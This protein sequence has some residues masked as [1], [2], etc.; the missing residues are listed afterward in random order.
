MS[1]REFSHIVALAKLSPRAQ[2]HHLSAGEGAREALARRFGLIS[3]ARLEG[4]FD[5][6]RSGN[7]ADLT[8]RMVADV[9]QSCIVSGEPVPAHVEEELTLRFEPQ[10]EAPDDLELDS[11]A[12]DVLPVEGDSIDLGEA[13]AQSLALALD[14]WPRAAPEQLAAARRHL[15]TEA[16][17]EAQAEAEKLAASPFAK[18]RPK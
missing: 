6:S 1:T 3:I 7:G 16:E 17:A 4:D 9:V 8:G 2:P 12:L 11:G 15:I 14:P 18:L 13:L 10:A 5:V